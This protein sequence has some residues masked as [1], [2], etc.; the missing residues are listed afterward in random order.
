VIGTEKEARDGWWCPEAR[1]IATAT[2]VTRM[3]EEPHLV[4]AA[5]NRDWYE[6]TTRC[7]A[8]GCAMWRWYGVISEGGEVYRY[9]D[10]DRASPPSRGEGYER[11][12]YCGLAGAP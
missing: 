10:D 9:G 3:G 12:G 8:S 4:G 5:V 11:V 1:V 6:E 7:R 2:E